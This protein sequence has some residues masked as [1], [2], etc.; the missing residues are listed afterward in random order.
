VVGLVVTT[1]VPNPAPLQVALA[2]VTV[3]ALTWML[4]SE[5]Y[6]WSLAF[7]MLYLGLVDGYLKLSTGSSS[8][9]L[10]RDALLYAIV[11]GALARTAIRHEQLRMPPLTAWVVAWIVVVVIQIANPSDGTLLH[12]IATLRQHLE[13]V[14]L[15]FLA[16]AVMR[17]KARIKG[18]LFLLL[19]I[20]SIN[21]IVGLAQ[22]NMSPDQLSSWGSGYAKAIGGEGVAARTFEN[23]QGE[24]HVRPFGLGGDFGFGG[25]V[26][27]I[28]VP[29]ALALL[30]LSRRPGARAVIAVL[31][32]GVVLAIA[33]SEARTAVV[34]SVIAALVFAL[35]TV[36]SRAGLRTV[37]AIAIATAIAYGTISFISS[38]SGEESF[39]YGSISTPGKAIST[40]IEYRST[41]IAKVPEYATQFPLGAGFGSKGPAS[42][43]SGGTTAQLNA[44]SEATFLLIEVG[45]PGLAVMVGFLLTLF[46]LSVTRI[47]RV[48][49]RETRL[50][51]TAIAA[52]L[53]AIAS[54]WWV[55]VSTTTTPAGPYLWFAA[56]VLAFWLVKRGRETRAVDGPAQAAEG[57]PGREVQWSNA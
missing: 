3:G 22:L 41:T 57:A 6:A 24:V 17:S 55:G 43:V 51:L 52:P 38:N 37:I 1:R 25:V 14:P 26:G 33:T 23:E 9:T 29:A 36:T 21:G 12:S 16:Y 47:R 18:F 19:V 2:V 20:A 31:S 8:V 11:F 35:L 15:F 42:T 4:V 7:L 46:Y 28:A 30:T 53:F 13:W 48:P 54:T 44:E 40:A 56:G 32:A 49:D 34:G 50:L 45:I 27:M 10:V 5:R 39:R